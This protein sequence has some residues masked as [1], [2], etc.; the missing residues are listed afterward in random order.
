V[1]GSIQPFRATDFTDLK[2]TFRNLE[3]TNLTPYSG[4][5]AGR[6]IDSGK[7][8]VDLEYK[9]KDRQLAGENKFIVNK[10]KLG[11]RVDSP[12]AMKLPLDLAIALLEDSNGIIDLDLP[13]SGSLDDPQF[14]YG[15]IVWKAIVNVLTK[16]VTAPFRALGKLLGVSS[17]KLESVD[18][19]PGSSALL[20]PEQEK[21]KTLAEALAKRPALTLTLEPG[22]D[23]EAD[24][25]AL[26]ELAMRREAV[27][28][29]GIK[30]A[31]GEA[32]GPVDVNHTK[33][34][35]WLEDRYAERVGKPEYQKLRASFRD[36]DAGAAARV[37]ESELVER[38]ARRFKT[39]DEGPASA[40]HAE[41]LERLTRQTTIDDA[42][43]VKLA[44]ARGQAMR[45]AL[46]KLGLDGSRVS[47]SV[48]AQQ[49]AKDK[50]VGSRM[51]LGAGKRP[52]AAPDGLPA[53]ATP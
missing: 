53:A 30:L 52:A 31:P 42:A 41:L 20:P 13:V 32:P 23:P 33:I 47:V 11:E 21:L 6:R 49:S 19:D 36:K 45:D 8:S 22:Y 10:L 3:M 34:Q 1:R 9:I 27:A 7:L 18:F 16:L 38:L 50:L 26:Q 4:K 48:P 40:F 2:L 29:A 37:L 15:K 14:S 43:L 12:D 46:V 25:R 44:Q 39:R 24:R 51:S 17:E 35:T 5:F 28:V